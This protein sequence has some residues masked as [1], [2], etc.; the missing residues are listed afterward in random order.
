MADVFLTLHLN[1]RQVSAL[2]DTAGMSYETIEEKMLES[3]HS[4]Y[5]QLVPENK[6]AEIDAEIRRQDLQSAE[7]TS[8]RFAVVHLHDE[9]DDIHFTTELHD[10]FYSIAA[11]YNNYLKEDVG[12][13][14]LDSIA[15]EFPEAQMI[16]PLT[17]SVLC[18]AMYDDERINTVAEFDFE[19]QIVSVYDRNSEKWKVYDLSDVSEAVAH[20]ESIEGVSLETR[21]AVF[22]EALNGKEILFDED[23]DPFYAD[24]DESQVPTVQM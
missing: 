21:R 9:T 15:N 6:R 8:Q 20:A 16:N 4:L 23:G 10:N 12:R 18:S 24:E 17:F 1:E 5:E 19:N 7:K 11:L 22:E 2:T 14:T 3:F 13:L